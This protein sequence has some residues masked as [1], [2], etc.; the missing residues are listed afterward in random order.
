MNKKS[1]K[2]TF[3]DCINLNIFGIRRKST[4]NQIALYTHERKVSMETVFLSANTAL[5]LL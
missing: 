5:Q 2:K 4:R 1:S 3:I